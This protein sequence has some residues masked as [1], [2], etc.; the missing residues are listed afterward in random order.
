MSLTSFKTISFSIT[1][2][3]AAQ[4]LTPDD[5]LIVYDCNIY[6]ATNPI[7]YGN[8]TDCNLV[9]TASATL[10]FTSLNGIK[11]SDIWVKSQNSGNA[12]TV[13]VIGILKGSD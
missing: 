3:D 8:G 1:T 12:A 11:L 4:P 6:V 7:K 9:C 13:S 2:T 5:T 10:W